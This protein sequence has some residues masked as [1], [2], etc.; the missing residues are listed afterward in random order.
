MGFEFVRLY[1]YLLV[2]C[3]F[4]VTYLASSL[5]PAWAREWIASDGAR[6]YV[7]SLEHML[8]LAHKTFLFLDAA[9]LVYALASF[10]LPRAKALKLG[11]ASMTLL[12]TLSAVSRVS[13]L[14]AHRATLLAAGPPFLVLVLTLAPHYLPKRGLAHAGAS[15]PAA[16]GHGEPD[17]EMGVTDEDT[18]DAL[19]A[20]W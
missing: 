5:M 10:R 3:P 18:G 2:V 17:A 4:T 20:H 13:S 11:I 1:T 6:E 15:L 14:I 9:L 8:S 7:P 12:T 19:H 16:G